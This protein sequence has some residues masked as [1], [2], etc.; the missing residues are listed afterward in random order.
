MFLYQNM[1]NPSIDQD[2][3]LNNNPILKRSI[4]RAMGR[5]LTKKMKFQKENTQQYHDD[6]EQQVIEKNVRDIN[7]RMDNIMIERQLLNQNKKLM[8]CQQI[9]AFNDKLMK[10]TE[11]KE[12][13]DQLKKD[14]LHKT[15][16]QQTEKLQEK[17]DYFPFTHGDYLEQQREQVKAESIKF[18]QEQTKRINDMEQE[19]KQKL[20]ANKRDERLREVKLNAAKLENIKIADQLKREQY[21]AA[22]QLRE[23]DKKNDSQLNDFNN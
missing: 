14:K 19:R 8:V 18:C 15:Q 4:M 23:D 2:E 16:R 17:A 12:V 11:F 9:S 10:Q 20:L 7:E 13:N 21:E 22:M 3:Y 5:R 1:V 6:I